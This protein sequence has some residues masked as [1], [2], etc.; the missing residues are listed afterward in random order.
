MESVKFNYLYR[1]AG[2]YKKWAQVIFSNRERL[3]IELIARNLKEIFLQVGLFIAHQIRVPDAFLF[4]KGDAN[5]DDHC[6]H[7]FDAVEKSEVAP[8]DQ[9]TRSIGQFV[10]EASWQARI[11]WLAFDPHN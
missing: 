10:A 7:E 11:G 9:Y 6:F 3:P 5:S 1:D 4:G 8:N 2:N